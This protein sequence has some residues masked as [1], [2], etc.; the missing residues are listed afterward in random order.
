MS[1]KLVA[2]VVPDV[3]FR[4]SFLAAQ[5]ELGVDAKIVDDAASIAIATRYSLPT[6]NAGS[7]P[8]PSGLIRPLV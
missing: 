5:Q 2:L 6:T 3:R 4:A 1:E 7:A 8:E